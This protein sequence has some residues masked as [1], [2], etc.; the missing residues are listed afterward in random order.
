MAMNKGGFST[1]RRAFD[2]AEGLGLTV[3]LFALVAAI[4][5]AATRPSV[6]VRLDLTEG[7]TYT[8]TEQT[9]QVLAGLDEPIEFISIMRPELS[10]YPTGLATV[11]AEAADYVHSLLHE[12]E[13]ASGGKVTVRVLDPTADRLE[14]VDLMQSLHLARANVVLVRSR[15]RTEQVFLQELVTI[16]EGT[17]NLQDIHPAEIVDLRAEGPLTSALLSVSSEVLPRIG[18]LTAMGG[19]ALGDF[20]QFGLGLLEQSVRL[21]GIEPQGFE[22]QTANAVVPPELD[23]VAVI[24]PRSRLTQAMVDALAAFHA[25]GGALLLALDPESPLRSQ[26][27]EAMDGFLRDLGLARG[28]YILVQD[29]LVGEGNG[30]SV[31]PIRDF[32]DHDVTASIASQGTVATFVATGQVARHDDAPANVVVERLAR[33]SQLAFAD[34]PLNA[35]SSAGNY[36]LDPG[37]MR[38]SRWVAAARDRVG[39]D[40]RVVLFGTSRVMTNDTIQRGGAANLSLSLN[41]IQWLTGRQDALAVRPRTRFE[42]RVELFADEQTEIFSYVIIAMPLAGALLG[43]LVWFTRRR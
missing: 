7:E 4:V 33:T 39:G 40:G 3:V 2:V 8:L 12:Y 41:A 19:P 26:S 14:V 20:E 11:Q 30:D 18:F 1:G 43:L 24:G 25:D 13:L 34:Q 29:D 5:Y 10:A 31:L 32:A 15:N 38:G 6:R 28:R 21:Q 27:D 9:K 42:S 17:S 36:K 16:D 23:V 22:L 37:E 35:Q